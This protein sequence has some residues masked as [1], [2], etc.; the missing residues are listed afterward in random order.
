MQSVWLSKN[1]Y[2]RRMRELIAAI[3]QML[4]KWTETDLSSPV[5]SSSSDPNS[6]ANFSPALRTYIALKDHAAEFITYKNSTKRE[7]VMEKS[8]L[9]M[10]FGNI[11][12]KLKT[13]GLRAYTPPDGLSQVDMDKKWTE[14]L[15]AEATRSRTMNA[16]IGDVKETLRRKF[17]SLANDFEQKL[18]DIT[19]QISALDGPLE[20]QQQAIESIERNLGPLRETFGGIITADEECRLANIEENDHTVFTIEDLDFEFKLVENALMKKIKFIDN[21]IVSRNMTNLTPAQLE[22]FES[23]FRFFDQDETNTLSPPEMTA[24]LA[25]LGLVYSEG[26]MAQIHAELVEDYGA[27]TFEAFINLMVDITED[28]T[29]P[30]QLR[31]AFRGLA[32]DKAFV[33]EMD[34]KLGLL[35]PA[36]IDYLRE[37]MP[38]TDETGLKHNGT[39]EAAYDYEAWLDSVF[40]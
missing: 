6:D 4:Q 31:D 27:V 37:A 10:L 12:T 1:D 26:D 7:W 15:R 39:T 20:D 16:Q 17:A 14:L 30:E 3:N 24:A 8:D 34:L 25:S 21:Q 36:T 29:S 5:Q 32:G 18:R 22:Q 23:T 2:E 40:Q 35:P 9:A 11:Q 13:Y 38:T 19:S 28:Q 33:T